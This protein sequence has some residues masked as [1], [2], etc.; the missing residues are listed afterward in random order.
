MGNVGVQFLGAMDSMEAGA[1]HSDDVKSTE[2]NDSDPTAEDGE[3][4]G[5]VPNRTGRTAM[6]SPYCM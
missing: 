5:R 1:R 2:G 4:G 3:V 6:V